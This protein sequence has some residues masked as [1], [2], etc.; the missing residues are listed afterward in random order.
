MK[1]YKR[2]TNKNKRNWKMGGWLGLSLAVITVL[3][4]GQVN[5]IATSGLSMRS[6]ALA[7][8]RLQTHNHELE[9]VT[10]DLETLPNLAA[11]GERL[12][13]VPTESLEYA[14]GG[15]SGEVARR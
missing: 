8:E 10:R 3:Y 7:L 9:M 1:N 5:M 12:Q 15:L 14:R 6:Q 4:L 13:L 11:A 2:R